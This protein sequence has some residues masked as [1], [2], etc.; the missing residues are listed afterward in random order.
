MSIYSINRTFVVT[1]ARL[2]IL[3]VVL[4]FITMALNWS[5]Q[6]WYLPYN[7]IL[8]WVPLVIALLLV[9]KRFSPFVQLILLATWLAFLPN[10]YYLVTDIIHITEE[11][12]VSYSLDTVALF[13]VIA[14]G[15]AAG[16]YSFLLIDQRYF[17]KFSY[18]LR[19]AILGGISLLVSVGVY[20][21]RTLRWNSWDLVLHP[22][23]VIKSFV[24]T[25]T[26]SWLLT[27]FLADV[28]AF[29]ILIIVCHTLF[30]HYGTRTKATKEVS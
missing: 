26:H 17:K 12:R 6:Y 23:D 4:V 3:G 5:L 14:P 1:L 8:A 18:S 27:R 10:A 2:S 20:L 13:A 9:T 21:G 19:L 22:F 30:V 25:F 28:I 7:L 29:L 11:L 15:V 24:D 16:A